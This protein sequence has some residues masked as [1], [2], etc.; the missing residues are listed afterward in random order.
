V[1][2]SLLVRI[3]SCFLIVAAPAAYLATRGSSETKR[4][5]YAPEPIAAAA[6]RAE[7]AALTLAP[8]WRWPAVPIRRTA[9]DGR[10]MMYERGFGTQAADHYWYCSWAA[11]ALDP[12]VRASARREAVATA[13]S[14]RNTYYFTTALAP[15]SR[16][17]VE[18]LLS[19]AAHGDLRALRRDVELN[20]PRA[21][22]G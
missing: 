13:A 3:V 19:R 2:G 1:S 9:P 17:L 15:E 18:D 11:H 6:F 20:C 7:A 4:V 12:R 21:P 22:G 16:P 8:G 10:Q 14:L 5:V